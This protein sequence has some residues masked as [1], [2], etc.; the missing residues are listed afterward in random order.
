MKTTR[1]LARFSCVAKK[2]YRNH[3]SFHGPTLLLRKIE[4]LNLEH[5]RIFIVFYMLHPILICANKKIR[6]PNKV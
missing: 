2:R 3:T 1:L 4:H 5:G 6:H